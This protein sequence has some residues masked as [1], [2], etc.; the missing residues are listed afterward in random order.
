MRNYLLRILLKKIN[1]ASKKTSPKTLNFIFYATA[2]LITLS[3]AITHI[4]GE[5]LENLPVNILIKAYE[6]NA[7]AIPLLML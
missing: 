3:T 6:T 5:V 7:K 2:K 1:R 4:A